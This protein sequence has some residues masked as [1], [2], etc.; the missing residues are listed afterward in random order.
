MKE[1]KY[2]LGD[3]IYLNIIAPHYGNCVGQVLKYDEERK[4]YIVL[5]FY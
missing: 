1:L 4:K 5:F 3:I 2:E